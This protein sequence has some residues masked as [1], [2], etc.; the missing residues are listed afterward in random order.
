MAYNKADLAK[1]KDSMTVPRA[2]AALIDGAIGGI[3]GAIIGAIFGFIY[4]RLALIGQLASAGFFLI[5]D[6]LLDGQSPGKKVMNLR[7]VNYAT[8]ARVTQEESIKRNIVYGAGGLVGVIGYLP[9]GWLLALPAS[10]ALLALCVYEIYVWWTDK[11][12]RRWGDQ[13]AGTAVI[14]D[15]PLAVKEEV[16][17]EEVA[18]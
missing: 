18:Q 9:L 17:E 16:E 2:I 14:S 10:L 8:G 12:G 3:G 6:T 13:F 7:A 1:N 15:K 11:E 4:W 5:R